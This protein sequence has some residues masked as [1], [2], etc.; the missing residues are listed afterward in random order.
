MDY[1]E[2]AIGN[3]YLM[4]LEA[5][6]DMFDITYSDDFV[7]EKNEKVNITDYEKRRLL[8]DEYIL[9]INNA[10]DKAEVDALI[11]KYKKQ[12]RVIIASSVLA[13]TTIA[14][15]SFF[16]MNKQK[17]DIANQKI[18]LNKLSKRNQQLQQK[19]DHMM[20][21]NK[22]LVKNYNSL[23]DKYRMAKAKTPVDKVKTGVDIGKRRIGETKE[24]IETEKAK[25]SAITQITKDIA[26]DIVEEGKECKKILEKSKSPLGIGKAISHG[27]SGTK[28]AV[29]KNKSVKKHTGNIDSKVKSIRTEMRKLKD[30]ADNKS[31]PMS[32]RKKAYDDMKKCHDEI[33]RLKN[34]K[35]AL[36][37]MAN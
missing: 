33:K 31:L 14:A 5:E 23:M 10:N 30:I 19:N 8:A 9:R 7:Y 16:L 6:S 22:E 3:T 24:S 37:S 21:K 36:S 28:K 34:T 13:V 17:K 27:I 26:A 25:I 12:R 1:I 2:Y 29:D 35:D 11:K 4:L 20:D 18:K 15:V 32:K